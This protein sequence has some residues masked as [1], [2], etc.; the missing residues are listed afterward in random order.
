MSTP[1]PTRL[2]GP[3]EL[4]ALI[5]KGG[6]GE[7]WKA[8]DTR[9]GRDVAVKISSQTFSDRFEREARTI[10]SLNHPNVCTLYDVGP[11]YLVM[12][13]IDGSEL[14]GPTPLAQAVE[15]GCRILDALDAAHRRGIAHRDLKPA[16][17]LVTK[18][19]IKVLDFGLAKLVTGPQTHSGTTSADAPT[20]LSIEGT[21]SGTLYYMAPE[22]LQG[23]DVDTRADI[24][25]FGCVLYEML[26]GKRAFDGPDAAS[27]IAGVMQRPAPSVEG[28]V[29]S[30]LSRI[31]QRCLEKD[32][33]DR[34]QNVRDLK[35]ELSRALDQPDAPVKEKVRSWPW[36]AATAICGVALA[37]ISAFHFREKSPAPPDLM[38]FQI[39]LPPNVRLELGG[40]VSLS[41][42]GRHIAFPAG[43][44]EGYRIYVQDLDGNPAR[45]LINTAVSNASPPFGWSPD[46]AYISYS[47]FGPKVS[48][49]EIA[50]GSVEDI[51]DK[52]GPAIGG[53]WNRAGTLIFGSTTTGLWRV[54]A[55]GG[56]AERLTQLDAARREISHQL[57]IFLPDG[58]HYLYLANSSERSQS[59]I[60]VRSLDDAPGRS[61][62]LLVRTEF[63]GAFVQGTEAKKGWL[64]YLHG[65]SLLAQELD[66]EKLSLIG[67]PVTLPAK[68]G[69]AY[70][71]ALFSVSPSLLV[72]RAAG[73]N[74]Q[75]Q[76]TWVDAKTGKEVKRV[77]EPGMTSLPALS[78]DQKRV[79]YVKDDE[80]GRRDIWVLDLER[81]GSIRLTF[82]G[83]TSDRPVWSP[84]GTEIAFARSVN[85]ATWQI[86]KRR[87][88]GVGSERLLLQIPG[89]S[90]HPT[91]WSRSGFM[92][93]DR[94]K[95][96]SFSKEMI[97]MLSLKD[98]GAPVMFSTN[99]DLNE[100]LARF[101][102]DGHYI[103]Y[104][105]TETGTGEIYVR[106][107]PLD[108]GGQPEGKWLI[109]TSS[110]RIPEWSRDGKKLTWF[111]NAAIWSADVDIS[112]GFHAGT[113]VPLYSTGDSVDDA[114]R[115]TEKG[116]SLLL[117]PVVEGIDDPINVVVN[118]TSILNKAGA[119]R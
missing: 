12:E 45:P 55:S 33:D 51:C 9:L 21:I 77:G 69:T 34:W 6:M 90:V 112:H 22:Q 88:D 2:L 40:T 42:D 35:W 114:V 76:L 105:S 67:D 115:L 83:G 86:Y 17:I 104:H 27:V 20:A 30:A 49:V 26:T 110:G 75:V 11:N 85:N 3:Y 99:P 68:V 23:K 62:K 14:R 47:N 103:A 61:S 109:S 100:N 119:R 41:P 56:T 43:S 101:S 8:R 37:A 39:R 118:W 54:A 73:A 93:F 113:P 24:F 15:R 44:N 108:P 4:I 117:K 89:E 48:K 29:P 32:A 81:G 97:G 19:G 28:D 25:A 78:P 10:A 96:P 116:Q 52:P 5:G 58:K 91:D 94:S 53:A 92:L 79:A 36:I 60:L 72:Y 50:T 13:L 18:S 16:N 80:N 106:T 38:R 102:P 87:A 107:F 74:H 57:P 70:Q 59:G 64:L 31:L 46:S 111:Y 71:T 82:G 7:V 1:A 66:I 65:T 63:G 95:S 98:G 84:D